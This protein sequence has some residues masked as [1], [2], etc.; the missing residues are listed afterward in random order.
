M[1][2]PSQRDS[3]REKAIAKGSAVLGELL[4]GHHGAENLTAVLYDLLQ[5]RSTAENP[6][7]LSARAGSDITLTL[8]VVTGTDQ[9]WGSL[10][11]KVERIDLDRTFDV[12]L[13]DRKLTM[14]KL[15]IIRNRFLFLIPV[16]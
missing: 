13:S 8:K 6:I 15:D 2:H 7:V 3:S 10:H 9:P 1:T 4:R 11:G 12:D 16:Y 14:E 5:F